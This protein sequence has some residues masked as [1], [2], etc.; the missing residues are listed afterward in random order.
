MGYLLV[1]NSLNDNV[2]IQ[3]DCHVLYHL[4]SQEEYEVHLHFHFPYPLLKYGDH[5]KKILLSSLFSFDK[6]LQHLFDLVFKF[7]LFM[8]DLS[9]S[10]I[11]FMNFYGFPCDMFAEAVS[12]KN[13]SK[14]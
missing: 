12:S 14:V 6:E 8:D 7:V 4:C 9:Y 10:A 13:E 1:L 5:W 11:L 2:R 3:N